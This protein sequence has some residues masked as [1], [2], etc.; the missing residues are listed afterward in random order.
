VDD[1][2]KWIEQLKEFPKSNTRRHLLI[3]TLICGNECQE[4]IQQLADLAI[5]IKLGH[6]SVACS[7]R[8][9]VVNIWVMFISP[10]D[11][12]AVQGEWK[13]DTTATKFLKHCQRL[14]VDVAIQFSTGGRLVD[15]T[16][17]IRQHEPH[18]TR[19]AQKMILK[20]LEGND[21]LSVDGETYFRDNSGIIRN[22][23]DSTVA[24]CHDNDIDWDVCTKCKKGFKEAD[25][26]A[27]RKCLPAF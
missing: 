6:R 4:L 27:C 8:N 5:P 12:A 19:A 1:V 15:T 21:E 3:D 23:K 17:T 14:N 13:E 22:K 9:G 18:L 25:Q 20:A 7:Y 26:R 10:S 2:V 24:W 11:I 16:M